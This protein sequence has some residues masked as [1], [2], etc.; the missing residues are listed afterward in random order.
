MARLRAATLKVLAE[1]DY[2][3]RLATMA[4]EP[5]VMTPEQSSAYVANEVQKWKTVT[6]A[7]RIQLD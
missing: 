7:A 1:P 4:I 6:S 2:A 3:S 5:L